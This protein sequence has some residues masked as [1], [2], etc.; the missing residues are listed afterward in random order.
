MRNLLSAIFLLNF[1]CMLNPGAKFSVNVIVF[2]KIK[3]K[4]IPDINQKM[5]FVTLANYSRM[6]SQFELNFTQSHFI[7][8]PIDPGQVM[9]SFQSG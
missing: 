3:E 2:N 7:M 9:L 5:T 1:A 4:V 6:A 8:I